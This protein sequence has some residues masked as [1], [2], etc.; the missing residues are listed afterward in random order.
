MKRPL[1]RRSNPLPPHI[2]ATNIL[3]RRSILA[4][5]Q[6]INGCVY[7]D[8]KGFYEKYFEGRHWSTA[9]ENIVRAVNPQIMVAGLIIQIH[10][11][12]KLFGSGSGFFKIGSFK[13]RVESP[14]LKLV[15]MQA[16]YRKFTLAGQ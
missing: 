2:R 6:G 7:K 12:R 5:S 16:T 1:T 11:L 3:T 15:L 10:R 8:I 4:S 14:Q 9:V 13:E